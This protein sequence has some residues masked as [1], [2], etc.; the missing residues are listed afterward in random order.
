MAQSFDAWSTVFVA[1]VLQAVPFLV[2]GVLLSAA[3][4]VAV[5]ASVW[6]RLLGAPTAI[7][8]PVAVACGAVVPG[9]ECTSVPM[10]SRLTQRGVSF[11]AALS[12]ALASPAMNPVVMIA[13]LTAFAGEWKFVIARFVASFLAVV[14]IGYYL[15]AADIS[16]LGR[17][18][19][20]H[21]P[22]GRTWLGRIGD[23]ARHDLL[24][25]IG[26]VVLGAAVAATV[27]VVVPQSWLLS[28][29]DNL[30]LAIAAMALLAILLALCSESDAFVA[31]S[32]VYFPT[33][34]LLTFMVVGP[35]IDVRLLLMYR[36]AFGSRVMASI[37]G[38]GLLGTITASV[39]I[40]SVLL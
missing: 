7:A 15:A 11:P 30:W 34:S 27:R 9:C 1:M 25:T 17:A 29:S 4:M 14:T 12:F 20:H 33:T 22:V 24:H 21:R 37:I 36:S 16:P 10:A 28:L 5:P 40:G 8:V 32:F 26:L 13:T 3:V 39:V 35:I 38:Y 23:S 31:A 18:R 2:L 19:H 6:Q